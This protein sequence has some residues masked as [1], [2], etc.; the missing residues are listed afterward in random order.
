[1]SRCMAGHGDGFH[2]LGNPACRDR[3]QHRATNVEQ[4]RGKIEAALPGRRQGLARL[5][6][7]EKSEIG[8]GHPDIGIG[9]IRPV[10]ID[11]AKRMIAMN[12]GEDDTPYI[13]RLNTGGYHR[14]AGMAIGSTP[15]SAATG[16]DQPDA[17]RPGQCETVD[18]HIHRFALMA[19][20]GSG[21]RFGT[22][23]VDEMADRRLVDTV[24]KTGNLISAEP[25]GH[26]HISETALLF[27]ETD[28][29][30]HAIAAFHI[31][32]DERHGVAHAGRIAV[33]DGQIGPDIGR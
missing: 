28:D 6:T 11:E 24:D 31:G 7:A 14:R 20:K 25:A 33:H 22:L 21:Q 29:A 27:Q 2:V 4:P 13:G 9:K 23:T 5:R 26:C 17:L 10:A 3:P 19:G 30:L 8:L 12:M 15:G 32:E 18:V 1:M 16:I